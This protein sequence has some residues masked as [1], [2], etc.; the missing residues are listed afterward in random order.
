MNIQAEVT[1]I[2]SDVRDVVV[3]IE[4]AKRDA[5]RGQNNVDMFDDDD[6]NDKK[7]EHLQGCLN[8]V[9]FE[10]DNAKEKLLEIQEYLSKIIDEAEM[11]TI[12][13]KWSH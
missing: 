9:T 4:E 2:N 5:Q 8:D 7:L 6:D 3:T 10:L 11:E 13:N 1:A 12:R